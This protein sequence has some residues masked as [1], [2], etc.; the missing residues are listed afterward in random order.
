MIICGFGSRQ[1]LFLKVSREGNKMGKSKK[2]LYAKLQA[3]KDELPKREVIAALLNTEGFSLAIEEYKEKFKEA[4][5]AEDKKE[6]SVCKKI[7]DLLIDF[8]GFLYQQ[9]ERAEKIPKLINEIEWNLSQGN[10]F[11]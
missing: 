10:L 7:L 11:E 8:R 3:L 9:Q 5:D 1:N 2:E 4:V 6:I